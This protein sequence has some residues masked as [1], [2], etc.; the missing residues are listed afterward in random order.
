MRLCLPPKDAPLCLPSPDPNP[1]PNPDP[2]PDPHQVNHA[3]A[4]IFGSWK[5]LNGSIPCGWDSW[6][7]PVFPNDTRAMPTGFGMGGCFQQV[8]TYLFN[9][10][11][12]S[13]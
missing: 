11:S 3:E 10:P 2:D 6:Q 5:L 1:N 7:A 13:P 4:L 9:T 12:P 8:A